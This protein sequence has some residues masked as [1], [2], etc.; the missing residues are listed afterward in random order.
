M[1]SSITALAQT[2]GALAAFLNTMTILFFNLS[3]AVA[4]AT[5]AIRLDD[6]AAIGIVTRP[7]AT[8]STKALREYAVNL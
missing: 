2:P 8:A 7:E 1:V 3:P 5:S 6:T 4:K